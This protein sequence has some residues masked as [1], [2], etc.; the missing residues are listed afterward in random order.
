MKSIKELQAERSRKQAE[1]LDKC[2]DL[3]ARAREM[4]V[5]MSAATQEA[6][7]PQKFGQTVAAERAAWALTERETLRTEYEVAQ[8]D[9]QSAKASRREEVQANLFGGSKTASPE[10]LLAAA[11]ATPSQL[12]NMMDLALST[13]NLAAAQVAFHAAHQR[14]DDATV[15]HFVEAVPEAEELLALEQERDLSDVEISD[16]FEI[17]APSAPTRDDL[18][19]VPTTPT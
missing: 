17:I 8:V 19:M 12:Q 14:E 15:A 9:Y 13:G 7:G 6:L 10:Q 16:R 11:A 4:D 18:L 2:F 1:V 3:P 5:R